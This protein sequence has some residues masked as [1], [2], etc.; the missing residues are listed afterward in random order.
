VVADRFSG[1]L[2][3]RSGDGYGFFAGTNLEGIELEYG[4]DHHTRG[5]GKTSRGSHELTLR[6]RFATEQ[7]SSRRQ[8]QKSIRL[9]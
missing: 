4:Y 5:M 6:Y 1:G 7:L 2:F 3:W 9:L 8:P